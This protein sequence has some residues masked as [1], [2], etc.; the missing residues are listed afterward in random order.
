MVREKTE[1]IMVREFLGRVT[2]FSVLSPLDQNKDFRRWWFREG[3][4]FLL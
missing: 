4:A 1:R 2:L 3:T